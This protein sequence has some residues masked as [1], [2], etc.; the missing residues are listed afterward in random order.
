MQSL[1]DFL[2]VID[3]QN[4]DGD[5]VDRSDSSF[6]R[7][8]RK[9]FCRK[10]LASREYRESLMRRIILGALPPAIEQL[11]YYYAEG[12]PVE[13]VEHKDT[14]NAFEHLSIDQLEERA[15]FLARV[16][17]EMRE[18]DQPTTTEDKR[19]ERVH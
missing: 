9:D 12:K 16:A 5:P 15:M 8:T 19:D 11:L 3:P 4:P 2:G 6:E 18:Q 7:M 14:T 13:R 10:V 1:A 17:R